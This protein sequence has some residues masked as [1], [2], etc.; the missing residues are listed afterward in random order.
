[1]ILKKLCLNS[2]IVLV[3]ILAI[4]FSACKEKEHKALISTEYGDITVLLYNTTPKHRDN[5]IKL[6]KEGFYDDL[7][8]HRVIDK[9]M[10]QGGD[11]ESKNSPAGTRLG[12]A[13]PGY[14]IDAEIG[15]PHLYGTVAAARTVN[16]AKRSSGS[17]FFIVT[18]NLQNENELEFYQTSKKIKYNEDQLRIYKEK[19][20]YPGLDMEYTVFG[21]VLSGMDVVEKISKLE[22]DAVDRPLKD[23]KMK[24]KMI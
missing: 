22:K 4:S 14:E 9:F 16:Q 24:I 19:G 20:G 18:G 8:F 15:A 5:F 2:C 17:Q 10:I 11:P 21:E 12:V 6:V 23:V 3:I 7:L 1:M 13:G